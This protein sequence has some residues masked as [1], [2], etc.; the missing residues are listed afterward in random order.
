E[1]EARHPSAIRKASVSAFLAQGWGAK[2]QVFRYL[3]R[4]CPGRWLLQTV[5]TYSLVA[6]PVVD[7]GVFPQEHCSTAMQFM[8]NE[9]DCIQDGDQPVYTESIL[10]SNGW[11]MRLRFRDVQVVQAEPIYPVRG[12]ILVPVAATV[13][14]SA[15]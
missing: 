1:R 8:Y 11:E 5:L 7:T 3:S 10:L 6:D 15:E 12:T 2:P 14:Q 4:G 9:V 13:P